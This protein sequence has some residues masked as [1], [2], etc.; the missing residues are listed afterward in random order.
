MTL[1][2]TR[3]QI[4]PK[5]AQTLVEKALTHAGSEGWEVA[6]A[7]CDPFGYLV[8]FGRTDS[9][10]PPIGEFALDKAYTAA[11]LRRSTRAFGERMASSQTLSLGLSTRQRFIAWGGGVAIFE[12]GA[13]IGGIG[14]SGAQDH[15]DI[16]CAEAAIRA[17]GLAPG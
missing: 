14:V 10:A 15:E 5:A 11:T 8:A 3:P 7:V 13:C 1:S 12:G 4:T 17:L 9:V 6:V 2:H 16:A